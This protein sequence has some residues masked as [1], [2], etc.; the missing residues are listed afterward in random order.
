MTAERLRGNRRRRPPRTR[1]LR[2]LLPALLLVLVGVAGGLVASRLVP[3]L[4]GARVS[5]V[6]EW[7]RGERFRLRH[8]DW[9]GLRTL[10][11][12]AL[13]DTL[14]IPAD[15]ALIDLDVDAVLARLAK[16]PRVASA[17]GLRIPPDRLLLSVEERVP[18]A[19]VGTGS[20]GVDAAGVRFPLA[21]GEAD[22]LPLLSGDASRALPLVRAARERGV[23]LASVSAGPP[24]D[25]RFR[26]AD[27][28]VV[29][30]VGADADRALQDWERVATSG[31]VRGY[32]AGEVDLRFANGA[33]LRSFRSK[34]ENEGGET[35]EQE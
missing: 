23:A 31:L 5:A 24:G 32:G 2:R 7:L 28:D 17:A 12:P 29:V 27:V 35:N 11:G 34:H 21:P 8:V 13:V 15:T 22:G 6:E 4:F 33:V 9:L 20:E 10:E 30:R 1:V 3:A 14:G 16:H 18:I 19:V 25:V 26:P